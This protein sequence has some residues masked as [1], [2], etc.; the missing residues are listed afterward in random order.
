MSKLLVCRIRHQCEKD[1][2][3]VDE[4]ELRAQIKREAEI[5]EEL[6]RLA[7]EAAAAANDPKAKKAPLKPG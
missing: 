3:G 1:A 2:K 5:E 6:E 7:E 4:Q